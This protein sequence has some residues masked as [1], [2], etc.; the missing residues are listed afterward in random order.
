YSASRVSTAR[1]DPNT[2][3]TSPIPCGDQRICTCR[4]FSV[5]G[6]VRQALTGADDR[7]SGRLVAPGASPPGGRYGDGRDDQP[8]RP[9]PAHRGRGGPRRDRGGPGGARDR[10]AG[11]AAV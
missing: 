1:R 2:R 6:G 3:A 8:T 4:W 7:R 10:L 9:D 11:A 5:T